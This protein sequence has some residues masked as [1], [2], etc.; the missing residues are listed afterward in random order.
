MVKGTSHRRS[1][2]ALAPT[3][4]SDGDAI[5]KHPTSA[6]NVRRNC[7]WTEAEHRLFLLGLDEYGRGA[8]RAIAGEY[9]HTRTATQVRRAPATCLL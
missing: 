5:T 9:V 8:W 4:T 1:D 2:L 6:S 3:R 7:P